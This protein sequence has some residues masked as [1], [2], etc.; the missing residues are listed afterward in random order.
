MLAER[1]DFSGSHAAAFRR[2]CRPLILFHFL[3]PI[4]TAF[5]VAL[6]AAVF[7]A[8]TALMAVAADSAAVIGQAFAARYFLP[9]T[10]FAA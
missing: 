9:S 2:Y 6:A 5:D 8:I 1:Q 10:I 3:S 7:I 4:A